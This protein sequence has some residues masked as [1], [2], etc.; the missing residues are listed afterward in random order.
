MFTV[1]A[2]QVD[3]VLEKKEPFPHA[4]PLALSAVLHPESMALESSIRPSLG[5]LDCPGSV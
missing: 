4:Q 5:L 3:S 2:F 1:G